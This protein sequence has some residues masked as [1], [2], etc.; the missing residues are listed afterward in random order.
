MTF[1]KQNLFLLIIKLDLFCCKNKNFKSNTSEENRLKTYQ[2]AWDK[3]SIGLDTQDTDNKNYK[4]KK[5]IKKQ[6]YLNCDF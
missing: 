4:T 1:S 5:T 3:T 2:N 6:K